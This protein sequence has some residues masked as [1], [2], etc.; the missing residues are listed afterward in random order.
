MTYPSRS[1]APAVLL[2]VLLAAF[3]GPPAA[4]DTP[5]RHLEVQDRQRRE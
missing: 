1:W 2:A 4:D 3:A 5:R